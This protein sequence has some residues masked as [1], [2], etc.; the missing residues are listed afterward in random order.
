M[1]VEAEFNGTN[2]ATLRSEG[3]SAL[4]KLKKP[5]KIQKRTRQEPAFLEMPD[6]SSTK[7]NLGDYLVSQDVGYNFRIADD[8]LGTLKSTKSLHPVYGR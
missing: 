7:M 3:R 4:K 1:V 6:K 8:T 5:K 2:K